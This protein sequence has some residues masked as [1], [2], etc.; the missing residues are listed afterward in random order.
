MFQSH[1]AVSKVPRSPGISPKRWR[2]NNLQGPQSLD[3]VLKQQNNYDDDGDSNNDDNN[4][5][6]YYDECDDDDN[7]TLMTTVAS[8]MII[9]PTQQLVHKCCKR[10]F[11]CISQYI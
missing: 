4:D 3:I 6:D 11:I 10:K 9:K 2:L 1:K 8:T 5:D 7:D